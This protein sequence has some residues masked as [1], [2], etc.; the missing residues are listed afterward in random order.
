M[1]GLEFLL[2]PVDRFPLMEAAGQ[3]G[4]PLDLLCAAAR[5]SVSMHFARTACFSAAEGHSSVGVIQG[6]TEDVEDIYV[7]SR[8]PRETPAETQ[9]SAVQDD[10]HAPGWEKRVRV[11]AAPEKKTPRHGR[12]GAIEKSVRGYAMNTSDGVIKPE[13]G[14]SFDS[15]GEAY[16]F[17]NLY[18]WETGFGIRYGKSRFN[19]SGT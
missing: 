13:L 7:D 3:S 12:M 11:G 15:L 18:S 10:P 9:G 8:G 14:T 16:N 6:A 4:E 2:D 5:T 19:V 17:C 1:N